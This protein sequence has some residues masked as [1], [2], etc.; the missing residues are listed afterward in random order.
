[1]IDY[2]QAAIVTII[3][4]ILLIILLYLITKDRTGVIY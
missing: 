2:I 3:T 1:M 4:I